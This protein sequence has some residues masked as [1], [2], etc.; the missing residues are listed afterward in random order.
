M[1]RPVQAAIS[2]AVEAMADDLAKLAGIGTTP[3]RRAKAAPSAPFP[4]ETRRRAARAAEM[5]PTPRRARSF[6]ASACT[7][8]AEPALE[9]VRFRLQ[10]ARASR[11][12]TQR[13]ARRRALRVAPAGRRRAQLS[14][15]AARGASLQT[16]SELGR[17]GDDQRPQ[18]VLSG[19][20][21]G[22]G[23]LAG[24]KQGT[25]GLRPGAEPGRAT[26]SRP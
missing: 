26:G 1:Q 8:R 4:D 7:R 5:G 22:D 12:R 21:R 9:R 25:Q 16:L 18:L 6:G 14:S 10:L 2:A 13:Q 3:A 19:G 24:D 20:A 23:A 15:S 17:S 11:E